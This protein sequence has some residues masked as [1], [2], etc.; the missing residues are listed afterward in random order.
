MTKEF[1]KG[2]VIF[3][4]GDTGDN[5]YQIEEGTVSVYVGYGEDD[6]TLL[7]DLGKGR[8][9][10][11][12][13]AVEDF[14]RS[15]TVVAK[16]DVKLLEIRRA[17]IKD[18]FKSNPDKIIE[19]MKGM[20]SRLRELTKDYTDASYVIQEL[21]NNMDKE[22]GGALVEL[23]MNLVTKYRRNKAITKLSAET[24]RELEKGDHSSGY[25]AEIESFDKGDIIFK[26]GEKGKCM[27]DIHFGTIG[28]YD[29]YGTPSEKLLTT[30][31][32]NMFFGELGMIDNVDR[33]CTAVA[34]EDNTTLEIITAEDLPELFEK[35]PQK[36]QMIFSHL[37]F[38]IRQLTR[39]Y[40]NACKTVDRVN[41]AKKNG[42]IDVN[43]KTTV[44]KSRDDLLVVRSLKL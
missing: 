41:E 25:S 44:I 26:E 1:K 10:G 16:E 3:R 14:P 34:M 24:E 4:E 20:T 13:A 8:F 35:N 31:S 21:S 39:E 11:E 32:A 18:F 28:I 5:V 7:T 27:Y 38:R 37:S 42:E 15:A 2:D 36:V 17:E 22:F 9:F 19:I 6:Q 40:V 29:G 33:S 43:L 30:L 23:I 12:M